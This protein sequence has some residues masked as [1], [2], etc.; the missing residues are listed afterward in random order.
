[1]SLNIQRFFCLRPDQYDNW[2]GVLTPDH[3]ILAIDILTN[4]AEVYRDADIVIVRVILS[5][6]QCIDIQQIS[7]FADP[8]STEVIL[9]LDIATSYCGENYTAE[10]KTGL[11]HYFPSLTGK[12]QV[13]IDE[14]GQPIMADIV[15][16][17]TWP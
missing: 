11:F 16:R 9:G 12:K 14:E 4:A 17:V 6:E 1:M 3:D 5:P 10:P 13:G 2:Q 15:R 7:D 8:L